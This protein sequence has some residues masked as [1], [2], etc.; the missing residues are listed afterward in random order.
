M[1]EYVY[2]KQLMQLSIKNKQ[3][4]KPQPNRKMD[5]DLNRRFSKDD[6]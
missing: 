6:M 3:T 2:K 1:P 5:K 4:K